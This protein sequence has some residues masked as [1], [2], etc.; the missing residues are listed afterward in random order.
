M[1]SVTIIH[2]DTDTDV[3][4]NTTKSESE[5][6]LDVLGVAPVASTERANPRTPAVITSLALYLPPGVTLDSDD[7]VR[8][9]GKL[10]TVDGDVGV[11]ANPFTSWQ[12]GS[13]VA[14][15]RWDQ[16]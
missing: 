6:T 11:W 10:Y 14:L 7:M 13:E 8:I 4:G 3:Y 5:T 16:P 1:T 12:A 9:D 2:T 15:R